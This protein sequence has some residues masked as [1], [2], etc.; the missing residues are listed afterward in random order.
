[1]IFNPNQPVAPQPQQFSPEVWAQLVEM[2]VVDDRGQILDQQL[3]Q[4]IAMR[5]EPSQR[6][7]TLGGGA[8]GAAGDILQSANSYAREAS[9]RKDQQ[10]LLDEKKAGYD[11]VARALRGTP[12]LTDPS[13]AKPGDLYDRE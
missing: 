8:L 12:P 2:G 7:S 13:N 11:A 10:K 5:H 6:H 1:M 9:L 4:A 3:A